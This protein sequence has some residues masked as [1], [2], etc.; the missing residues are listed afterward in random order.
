M[1]EFEKIKHKKYMYQL[2]LN[3]L[4]Y[5]KYKD[6]EISRFSFRNRYEGKK[7]IYTRFWRIKY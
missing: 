2:I 3:I 4:L 1:E 5:Y 6:L 7:N